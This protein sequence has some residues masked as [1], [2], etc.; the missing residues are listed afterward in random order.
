ME[1]GYFFLLF[2]GGPAMSYESVVCVYS[3]SETVQETV[4]RDLITLSIDRDFGRFVEIQF[5]DQTQK[6]QYQIL[7]ENDPQNE[8]SVNILQNLLVG[9][10]ESSAEFAAEAPSYAQI[11]HGAHRVRCELVKS[12]NK[13]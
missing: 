5:G 12:S 2:F 1:L 3:V 13:N 10:L 9:D 11:S 6:V 7:L 8:A 4:T